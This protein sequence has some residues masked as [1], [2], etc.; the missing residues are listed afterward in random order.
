MTSIDT[1]KCI[2][3]GAC[4]ADCQLR[5]LSL[6]DGKSWPNPEATCIECGHC[7]AICTQNAPHVLG[8]DAAADIKPYDA[9]SF[10][11]EPQR[12]QNFINFRRSMRQFKKDEVP[13]DMIAKIIEAGRHTQ[14]GANRQT[15]RYVVLAGDA[16]KKAKAIANKALAE[17]DVEKIDFNKIYMP[18]TYQKFQQTWVLWNQYYQATGVD[19]LL[20]D[21]PHHLVVICDYGNLFDTMLS[22]GNMELMIN[23]LGLGACST[24]FGT[25]AY[26]ISP[27]LQQLIGLQEGETVGF[28]MTFG[29][30]KVGYQRTT[31]RKAPNYTKIT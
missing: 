19:L 25:L 5:V 11:I 24:G 31:N 30:P 12:L 18:P 6:V 17:V 8:L 20:H 28:S 14:T 4:V 21:A 22:I 16:M 3:C 9:A 2:G 10:T 1:T 27:E 29:Y 23:A 15:L 7:E 13:D 26:H